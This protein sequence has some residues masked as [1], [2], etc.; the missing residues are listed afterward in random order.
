MLKVEG[1]SCNYGTASILDDVSIEVRDGE[2]LAIL[3][4]NGMGKTT[5][6]RALAGIDPPQVVDGSVVYDGEELL[7]LESYEVSRKL[8]LSRW[9]LLPYT[10]FFEFLFYLDKFQFFL[11]GCIKFIG[12]IDANCAICRI[13]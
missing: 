2:V 13:C 7:G 4:R 9:Y 1:L 3:G 11:C 5:L 12:F 8:A 6:V 10:R